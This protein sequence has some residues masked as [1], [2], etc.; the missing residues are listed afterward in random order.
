MPVTPAPRR[1]SQEDC[2]K[3]EASLVYIVSSR[4]AWTSEKTLSPDL[5]P[6]RDP[7][8]APGGTVPRLQRPSEKNGAFRC[9]VWW[10]ICPPVV[11]NELSTLWKVPVSHRTS[12]GRFQ[13]R[14]QRGLTEQVPAGV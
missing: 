8:S 10:V 1:L 14:L 12:A 3:F 5:R 7:E 13:S 11:G 2:C 4:P 9:Q 6:V